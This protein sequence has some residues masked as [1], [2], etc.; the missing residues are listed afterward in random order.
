[1]VI[2]GHSAAFTTWVLASLK[3]SVVLTEAGF[4]PWVLIVT[5][6]VFPS[7]TGVPKVQPVVEQVEPVDEAPSMNV[8]GGVEK[9]TPVTVTPEELLSTKRLTAS[10]PG[11]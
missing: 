8:P 10:V 1:M 11:L 3:C 4:A 5:D 2:V 7:A 9:S 6:F